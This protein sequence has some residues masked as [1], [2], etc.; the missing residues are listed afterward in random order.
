VYT[1]HCLSSMYCHHS[2]L[3]PFISFYQR[4]EERYASS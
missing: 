2:R 3:N 4:T 1:C